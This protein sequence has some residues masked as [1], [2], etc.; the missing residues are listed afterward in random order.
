[1]ICF[2]LLLQIMGLISVILA[3]DVYLISCAKQSELD[4]AVMSHIRYMIQ[5]N[6]MVRKC[7]W[8]PDTILHENEIQVEDKLIYLEDKQTYV[9]AYYDNIELWVYYDEFGIVKLEYQD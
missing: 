9:L 1:M 2:G 7:G 8:D 6:N 4:L 3:N 5:H